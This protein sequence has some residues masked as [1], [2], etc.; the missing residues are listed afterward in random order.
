MGYIEETLSKNENVVQNFTLNWTRYAKIY[1]YMVLIIPIVIATFMFLNKDV[2][3]LTF[4]VI[5]V[6]LVMMALPSLLIIKSIEQGVTNRKLVYKTGIFSRSTNEIR[7]EAIQTVEIEQSVWGRLLG[8]GN[9]H[10]TGRGQGNIT[11]EGIDNPLSVKRWIETAAE[12][13]EKY[14]SNKEEY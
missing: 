2:M 8:Y 6:P 7:L 11:L 14:L 1:A 9:V 12:D 13:R 3:S 10:V 4:F 5:I